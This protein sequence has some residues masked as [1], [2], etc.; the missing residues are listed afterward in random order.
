[1]HDK[2]STSFEPY[3]LHK[4]FVMSESTSNPVTSS[5]PVVEEPT[6]SCDV[7]KMTPEKAYE[8][9][10]EKEQA[11]CDELRALYSQH[12]KNDLLGLYK[13][14]QKAS[15]VRVEF[16]EAAPT[17]RGTPRQRVLSTRWPILCYA[18]RLKPQYLLDIAR[19]AE[20]WPEGD[21]FQREIV[22][23]VGADGYQLSFTI[24]KR[25]AKLDADQRAEW[26][27]KCLDNRW[28]WN[29]FQAALRASKAPQGVDH[30]EDGVAPEQSDAAED[31]AE[32]DGVSQTSEE[33]SAPP[34]ASKN[35]DQESPA[36]E[37]PYEDLEC[38]D[39]AVSMVAVTSDDSS[40]SLRETLSRHGAEL[41]RY[42]DDDLRSLGRQHPQ[43]AQA[44]LEEVS[45]LTAVL[46]RIESVLQEATTLEQA[47]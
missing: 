38:Q 17:T 47:A 35:R 40:E 25:L 1:M 7:S 28:T 15:A 42:S 6:V 37:Q 34:T 24:V 3:L 19:L 4:V 8:E 26:T 16:L 45:R 20:A 2:A 23:P 11:L 31:D 41:A 44:V 22:D 10:N 9:L 33:A 29:V 5:S 43:D 21:V 18:L 12:R 27:Q 46:N 13:L 14:G 39:A 32:W 36:E 30:E